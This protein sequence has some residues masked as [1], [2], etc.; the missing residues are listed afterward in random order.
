MLWWLTLC[1]KLTGLRHAQITGKTLFFSVSVSMFL[2]EIS[3]WVGRLSKADGSHQ[4]GQTS[5]NSLRVQIVEEGWE[6][7]NE[8]SY[9]ELGC[10]Y[11][12]AL[13]QAIYFD[14]RVTPLA[15]LVLRLLNLHWITPPV[16]LVL[17]FEDGRSWDFLFSKS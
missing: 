13:G 3:I 17:C 1:I 15:L 5:S 2:E 4:C 16:S 10:P 6:R 9:L 14:M 7:T 12:S 11:S 8:L